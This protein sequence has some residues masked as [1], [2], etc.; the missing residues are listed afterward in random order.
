M[1]TT[2]RRKIRST[3]RQI[4]MKPVLCVKYKGN[5][6]I[7]F[8]AISVSQASFFTST[9]SRIVSEVLSGKRENKGEWRFYRSFDEINA[10]QVQNYDCMKH[11]VNFTC[12]SCPICMHEIQREQDRK[13]FEDLW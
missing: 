8:H 2:W 10:P 11:E 9:N 5:Q 12:E 6:L 7:V 1:T 4:Q 13:L 3:I